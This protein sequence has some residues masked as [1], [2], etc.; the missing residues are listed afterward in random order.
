MI[1]I[2]AFIGIVTVIYFVLETT[3]L[4][5]K[6]VLNIL[7][8]KDYLKHFCKHEYTVYMEYENKD[9]KDLMLL[10]RKCGKR[11]DIRIWKKERI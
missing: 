8:R 6:K 1:K 3:V 2:F 10:C 9:F 5:I 7:E 4:N 11:K